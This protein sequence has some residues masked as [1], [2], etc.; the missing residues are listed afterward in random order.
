MAEPSLATTR[1]VDLATASKI[2]DAALGLARERRL[3]PM[4]I[5]VLDGGGDLVAF[6]RED[7]TGIRRYDIVLGKA[8]GAL[9]MNRPSRDIGAIGAR[10]PLFIETL[11]AATGGR[12]IP[13][14]GGVLI[15]NQDGR[16]V[17]SV[18]SSGDDADSDEAIA[19]LAVRAAGFI[20]EPAEPAR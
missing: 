6:K 3:R 5:A 14:P 10:A 1:G 2:V 11:A 15:K 13:T 16:I 18:G 9:V 17:G 19:I 12:V 20:P 7:G 4:T 8:F